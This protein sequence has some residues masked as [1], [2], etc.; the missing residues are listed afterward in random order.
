MNPNRRPNLRIC[1]AVNQTIANLASQQPP[2]TNR[3]LAT[4]LAEAH[5]R[6]HTEFVLN[7]MFWLSVERD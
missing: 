5:K 2:V 7:A 6:Y 3:A 4:A 1:F